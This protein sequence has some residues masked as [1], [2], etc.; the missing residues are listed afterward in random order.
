MITREE[1]HDLLTSYTKSD[2]LLKHA[3]A[4]EAAMRAYAAKFGENVDKWGVTGLIHDFDYE[5]FPDEHPARGVKILTEMG[6]DDDIVYA[7][8][9]HA[10]FMGVERISLMDKT[11]F[12]V[13]ELCGFLTAVALVRP[14]KS[15]LDVQVKSV[16]KKIKDKAFA[17]AVNRDDIRNGAEALGVTLEEHIAFTIEALH[18]VAETL[19][20]AGN[21]AV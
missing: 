13:D 17:R 11:L 7:V 18:P 4:V 9:S 6:I 16:K 5:Q 12:A 1:A 8:K 2:S 15:I 10:D 19:G 20:L 3:Y 21:R 14:S